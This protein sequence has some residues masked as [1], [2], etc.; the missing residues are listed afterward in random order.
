[1]FRRLGRTLSLNPA[2]LLSLPLLRSMFYFTFTCVNCVVVLDSLPVPL[3][4]VL[5]CLLSGCLLDL[6]TALKWGY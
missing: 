2:L 4:V 1:M 5:T 6:L 3:I